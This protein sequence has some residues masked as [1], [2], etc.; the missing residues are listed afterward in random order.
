MCVESRRAQRRPPEN[1]ARV[2]RETTDHALAAD[3]R[4]A[5]ALAPEL[6]PLVDPLEAF[7]ALLDRWRKVT[8][9]VSDTSFGE[10]WTRHIADSAQLLAIA[11]AANFSREKGSLRW[12]DLGTGAGFPGLVVAILLA[13]IVGAEVH[14]VEADKRKCAFLREAA[15]VTGAPA[16]IHPVRIESLKAGDIPAIDIVCARALSPLPRLLEEANPWLDAGALGVF[17]RGESERESPLD[18]AL[19][20]NYDITSTPNRIDSRGA[21]LLVKSLKDKH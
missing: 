5:I 1:V 19:A 18:A 11:A 20:R 9:L 6:A 21:I 16:I 4:K 3:R 2:S 13:K 10:V 15:R 17:P 7:V 8:N 12:L 14:C